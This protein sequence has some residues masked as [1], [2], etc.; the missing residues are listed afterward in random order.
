MIEV[1]FNESA[2]GSLKV[3]QHY[4]KGKYR[5]VSTVF[6][7]HSDGRQATKEEIE[8]AKQEFERKEREAWEKA[9]PLGGSPADVF[10]LA[11]VLSIGDIS[12]D[13]PGNKRQTVLEKLYVRCFPDFEKEH[14][15]EMID[16]TKDSLN[17]ISGRLAEGEP[18]RIWYSNNPDE[19]CGMY[20]FMNWLRNFYKETTPKV[21]VV[22]LPEYE[23]REDNAVLQKNSWG[24]VS[25]EEWSKY[26]SLQ[27]E[28]T[29]SVVKMY[30][31]QWKELQKENAMLRAEL[32]GSLASVSENIYDYYISREID[33][34]ENIFNAARLIGKILGKYRLGISDSLIH[35][36]I[37]EMI[38]DGKLE[39]VTEAEKDMPVYRRMLKRVK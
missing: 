14:V 20:W 1:V 39:V 26:V 30:A 38:A 15:Q 18:V 5:G 7:G 36:R 35:L 2:G 32:N 37:E 31:I 11:L 6:I 22:K 4:G 3:A 24:D 19:L 9:V 13:I 33:A 23:E 8:K 21:Y 16:K 17:V 12:E 28:V 34:C 10:C 27:K 29:E 25:A